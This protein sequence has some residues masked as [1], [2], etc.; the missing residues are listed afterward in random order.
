[1]AE[2]LVAVTSD[3]FEGVFS[4]TPLY[5]RRSKSFSFLASSFVTL[6]QLWGRK[7]CLVEVRFLRLHS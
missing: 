2:R 7:Q 5:T 6:S 3:K 4:K 1:M